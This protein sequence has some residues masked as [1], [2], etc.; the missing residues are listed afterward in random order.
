MDQNPDYNGLPS[1][2]ELQLLANTYFSEPPTEGL[3]I[4]TQQATDPAIIS[5]HLQNQGN[6][7]SSNTLDEINP[8]SISGHLN[9]SPISKNLEYG[10]LPSSVTGSGASPSVV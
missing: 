3:G 9:S 6:F 5:N 10:N 1:A 8:N 2:E 4:S 7:V